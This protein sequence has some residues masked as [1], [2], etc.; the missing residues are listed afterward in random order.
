MEDG[1]YV[2]LR[3]VALGYTLV[4]DFV[5]SLGLTSLDL[6]VAGR[7]LLTSTDYSGIDPETNLGG[8]E[9][10]V[11]GID[12]FNNP[13]TRSFVFTLGLTR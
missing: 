2:K 8:A 11:R 10:A 7:N 12:Y 5:R 9:I 6:R 13:Q 3:E 4:N 1:S